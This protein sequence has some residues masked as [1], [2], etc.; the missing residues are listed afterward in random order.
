MKIANNAQIIN[1]HE[2]LSCINFM[3]HW[4]NWINILAVHIKKRSIKD[5]VGNMINQLKADLE[6]LLKFNE[7]ILN[8]NSSIVKNAVKS[9]VET[10]FSTVST[11]IDS[12]VDQEDVDSED[13]KDSVEAATNIL[14]VTQ[15]IGK[16][17]ATTLG[18]NI[19]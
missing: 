5:E 18:G 17:M 1:G 6:N 15:D 2:N 14:N 12:Q 10:F 11:A 8:F 7:N 19:K 3:L 13:V 4:D 9:K 16:A